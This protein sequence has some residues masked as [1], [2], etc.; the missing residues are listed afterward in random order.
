M[1]ATDVALAARTIT[2]DRLEVA[3]TGFS[4]RTRKPYTLYRVHA[5]DEHG[6]PIGGVPLHTFERLSGTVEVSFEPRE[7]NGAIESYT[8]RATGKLASVR[9]RRSEAREALVGSPAPRV[10]PATELDA[11]RARID[12]LEARLEAA[13]TVFSQPERT[14]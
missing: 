2:V 4:P 1:S 5:N 12:A 8:L 3:R 14:A 6:D 13:L 10:Q 7:V 11:L 9:A